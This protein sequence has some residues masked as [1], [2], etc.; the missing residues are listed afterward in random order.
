[1]IRFAL[2]E[3][4][5]FRTGLDPDLYQIMDWRDILKDHVINNQHHLSI[6]GGGQNAR[7][8]YEVWEFLDQGSYF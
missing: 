6:S 3:L 8:A 1:M 4:E 2:N 5:L 7:C